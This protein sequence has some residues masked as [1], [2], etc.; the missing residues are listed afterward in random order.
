M[1]A[2]SLASYQACVNLIR[3]H[4]K[5][6]FFP[7]WL[8]GWVEIEIIANSAQLEL[9]LGLSLAIKICKI[10]FYCNIDNSW[11]SDVDALLAPF[12]QKI[13]YENGAQLWQCIQCGKTSPYITNI[14]NHVEANHLEGLTYPCTE[15]NKISKSR[16]SLR[17][18][19]KTAHSVSSKHFKQS[20]QRVY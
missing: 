6:Y 11:F 18:H 17:M 1:I 15:C 14:K 10:Q 7:G 2:C 3:W 8:G 12:M 16:A 4:F 5:L 20:G 13:T 9:E 19:M